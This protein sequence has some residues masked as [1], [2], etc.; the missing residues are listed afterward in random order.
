[1]ADPQYRLFNLDE[2]VGGGVWFAGH[3]LNDSGELLVT[4]S[5]P[6]P[7]VV[8]PDF[9]SAGAVLRPHDGGYDVEF[10]GV[11]LNG[12]L[13]EGTLNIGA[14]ERINELGD[15]IGNRTETRALLRRG[16]VVVDIGHLTQFNK[17]TRPKGLN[18]HG[19]V[20]GYSAVSGNWFN[21]VVHAF[22]YQDGVMTDLGGFLGG[23]RHFAYDINNN[24]VVVGEWRETDNDPAR[25]YALDI[26]S[27]NVVFLSS[28]EG[29]TGDQARAINKRGIIAGM[30]ASTAVLWSSDG[31]ILANLGKLPEGTTTIPSDLNDSGVVVGDNY[32]GPYARTA[33]WVWQDGTMVNLNDT[34]DVEG[35]NLWQAR[36]VNNKGQILAVGVGPDGYNHSVLLTPAVP[37][38]STVLLSV[39]GLFTVLVLRRR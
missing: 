19:A 35:W 24:N 25:A 36:A 29:S 14:P 10:V 2:V 20:V 27:G 28:L 15:V 39:V 3:D 17:Y 33:A 32:F 9:G 1:V 4:Y 8:P 6:P 38:P 23:V 31:E 22:L 30:T 16:G 11:P 21:Q 12:R 13:E 7:V 18:D 26:D 34:L 37:E 5:Q